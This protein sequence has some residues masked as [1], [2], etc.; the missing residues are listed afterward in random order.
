MPAVPAATSGACCNFRRPIVATVAAGRTCSVRV[1]SACSA[2]RGGRFRRRMNG[3]TKHARAHPRAIARRGFVLLCRTYGARLNRSDPAVR[4]S[5]VEAAHSC[6][7]QLR[8][9]LARVRPSSPAR[10]TSKS[11]PRVSADVQMTASGNAVACGTKNAVTGTYQP[12]GGAQGHKLHE[13]QF[14]AAFFASEPGPHSR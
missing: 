10:R 5:M 11:R 14:R 13:S 1:D 7:A 8:Y 3:Q 6:P 4:P 2:A 9:H 12:V